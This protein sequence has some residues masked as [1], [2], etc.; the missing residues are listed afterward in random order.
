MNPEYEGRNELPDNLKHLFCPFALSLPDVGYILECSLFTIGH[1]D[2]V[3]VSRRIALLLNT[4]SRI[5]CAVE[6]DFGLRI[7]RDLLQCI[8]PEENIS[9]CIHNLMLPRMNKN[10]CNVLKQLITSIFGEDHEEF[11]SE[12]GLGHD[13]T[14]EYTPQLLK[15]ASHLMK[16][17]NSHIGVYAHRIIGF[18]K[19]GD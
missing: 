8:K 9:K 12:T 1:P 14:Q 16:M 13:T 5:F 7:V 11:V 4:C 3:L 18:S 17:I 2:H 6:Y 15:A 10:D 19:Q